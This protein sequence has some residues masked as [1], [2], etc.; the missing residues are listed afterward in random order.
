MR[1][2]QDEGGALPSGYSV[3]EEPQ[4]AASKRAKVLEPSKPSRLP[5]SVL[6]RSAKDVRAVENETERPA[7]G[8]EAVLDL[9]LSD[10]ENS[11][12]GIAEREVVEER[13]TFAAPSQVVKDAPVHLP[14]PPSDAVSHASPSKRLFPTTRVPLPPQA[15]VVPPWQPYTDTDSPLAPITDRSTA[16]KPAW[17]Y[18]PAEPVERRRLPSSASVVQDEYLSEDLL[19]P[20]LARLTLNRYAPFLLNTPIDPSFSA[21]YYEAFVRFLGVSTNPVVWCSQWQRLLHR[22]F[23]HELVKQ[24]QGLQPDKE[25]I[26]A[27]FPTGLGKSKK[28]FPPH[29]EGKWDAMAVV[30]RWLWEYERIGREEVAWLVEFAPLPVHILGSSLCSLLQFPLSE[31]DVFSLQFA[32]SPALSAWASSSTLPRVSSSPI[33]APSPSPPSRLFK[34]RTSPSSSG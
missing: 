31:F 12:S 4:Q 34:P 15:A 2:E 3:A 19:F 30:M 16:I 27:V 9:T 28:K 32:T 29:L 25:A 22:H 10:E 6:A 8:K 14:S 17:S 23:T 18:N 13:R 5:P 1:P 11:N 26:R 24:I 20:S 33:S 7:D 21:S